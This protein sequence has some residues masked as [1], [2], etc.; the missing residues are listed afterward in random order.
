[1]SSAELPAVVAA[2]RGY[3][4]LSRW[5]HFTIQSAPLLLSF[6]I[7]ALT[8]VAWIAFYFDRLDRFPGGFD[9]I[10][11]LNT[12]MPLV[13]AGI[14]PIIVLLP[15]RTTFLGDMYAFGAMLSFTIAHLAVIALRIETRN[16][17]EAFK[18]R[19]SLRVRGVDWPLFAIFG[20]IG[21]AATRGRR[22]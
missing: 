20:A 18:L 7:L 2:P 12:S 6:I 17:P 4:R 15:G 13:F 16:D 1:M 5:R 19:P 3:R 9:W 11:V 14:V 10:T 22:F 8:V 21:Y